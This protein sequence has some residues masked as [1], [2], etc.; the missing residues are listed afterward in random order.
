MSAG[1]KR[2]QPLGIIG[3]VS[4]GINK[5]VKRMAAKEGYCVKCKAKKEIVDPR[6]SR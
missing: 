5:E 6:T 3:H 4:V 1:E 2:P